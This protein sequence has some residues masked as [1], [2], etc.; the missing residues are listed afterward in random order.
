MRW[1]GVVGNFMIHG[2]E[3]HSTMAEGEPASGR[4]LLLSQLAAHIGDKEGKEEEGLGRALVGPSPSASFQ[5]AGVHKTVR[6]GS[7]VLIGNRVLKVPH[8]RA[9]GD[10]SQL[11]LGGENSL[12]PEKEQ[13]TQ[14]AQPAPQ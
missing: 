12:S 10:S 5:R 6:S 1:G 11:E 13:E 3:V 4:T 9:R 14:P 8:R 7:A 2:G